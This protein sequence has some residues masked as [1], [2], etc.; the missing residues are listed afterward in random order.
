[1]AKLGYWVHRIKEVEQSILYKSHDEQDNCY[2]AFTI[3]PWPFNTQVKNHLRFA[4]EQTPGPGQTTDTIMRKAAFSSAASKF[5]RT[6]A[7][8]TENSWGSWTVDKMGNRE[9]FEIIFSNFSI[10]T[11]GV[12]AHLN[13]LNKMI[14]TSFP[15]VSFYRRKRNINM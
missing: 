12:C 10:K 15:T 2:T 3:F 11:Y 9:N 14:P 4:G 5:I 8:H 6:S 13:R 7:I 1:M